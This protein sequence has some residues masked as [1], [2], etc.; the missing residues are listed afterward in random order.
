MAPWFETFHA[1]LIRFLSAFAAALIIVACYF[2]APTA[3]ALVAWIIW[4]AVVSWVWSE[5]LAAG[6]G[7]IAAVLVLTRGHNIF[8]KTSRIKQYNR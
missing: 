8:S 2:T 7:G 6:I 3:R 5:F 1:W 4:I